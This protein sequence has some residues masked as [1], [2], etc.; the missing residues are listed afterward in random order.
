MDTFTLVRQVVLFAHV[1]AFAI[2]LSAVLRED[3]ALIKV[4]RIDPHRLADT[5]RTLTR[6]LIALW[7][8]GL[9]LVAFDVGLDARALI[10]S[11][12]L[13]AKLI[14]VSALTVN[15]LA[16][17]ALAFPILRRPQTQGR[18]GLFVPVVLGAISTVSWLYASFIGVSRLIAPLMN[19]TDFVALYGVLLTGAIAVAL[20]FVHPRLTRR[21]PS[22]GLVFFDANDRN[23]RMV[24]EKQLEVA[25]Q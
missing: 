4:R 11:P 15:G 10:A 16:L 6:V 2:A 9:A 14:V 23:C 3:V 7:V 12:K 21:S 24:A 8:T 20:V 5:A 1:V 17:H 25:Q 19:F 13:A 22:A 18:S